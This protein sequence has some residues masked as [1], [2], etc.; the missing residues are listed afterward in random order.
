M[1]LN[2]KRI[3]ELYDLPIVTGDQNMVNN[4]ELLLEMNDDNTPKALKQRVNGDQFKT[5][6]GEGSGSNTNPGYSSTKQTVTLFNDTIETQGQVGMY[7]GG[8]DNIDFDLIAGENYTVVFDGTSY[9]VKAISG[10]NNF[11]VLGELNNN[12]PSFETYPFFIDINTATKKLELITNIEG[13]HVVIIKHEEETVTTSP[14]FKSAVDSVTG[15]SI[16]TKETVLFDDTVVVSEPTELIPG[17]PLVKDNEYKVTFNGTEYTCKCFQLDDVLAIGASP[18]VDV[19]T[20][21]W[22]NYPFVIGYDSLD[23]ATDFMVQTPGTYTLKVETLVTST[24][25]TPEF[26]SMIQGIAGSDSTSGCQII[27]PNSISWTTNSLYSR[28]NKAP[29]AG[30]IYFIPFKDNMGS[31]LYPVHIDELTEG[32]NGFTGSATIIGNL[33]LFN[34][35]NETL[36]PL[37]FSGVINPSSNSMSG[38]QIANINSEYRLRYKAGSPVG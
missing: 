10:P 20:F 38:L 16:D 17:F 27:Y 19:M 7:Q 26:E 37:G 24:K 36:V 14:E 3:G 18:G 9:D 6:L 29:E 2:K 34:E 12:N 1:S 13:S 25:T 33:I 32:N 21:D 31:Y 5:I 8:V 22:S 35:V 4:H 28:Y 15:Y 23:V 30:N 11:V